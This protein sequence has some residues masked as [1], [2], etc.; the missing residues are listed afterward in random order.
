MPQIDMQVE[1]QMIEQIRPVM[2]CLTRQDQRFVTRY[3]QGWSPEKAAVAVGYPAKM[4]RAL[5]LKPE[6]C[7]ALE[8]YAQSEVSEAKVTRDGLTMLAYEAHSN[9][10]TATEQLQAIDRLAKLHGLY[11]QV[12]VHPTFQQNIQIN[13]GNGGGNEV[14]STRLRSMNDEELLQHAQ[15]ETLVDGKLEPVETQ[16][17]PKEPIEH[18]K[19]IHEPAP[20]EKPDPYA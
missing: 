9:A 10:A 12:G 14:P 15:F 19:P 11:D 18:E 7:D 20:A 2:S 13:T 3:I 6:I 16:T 4:G 5:L 17:P 8:A 1:R